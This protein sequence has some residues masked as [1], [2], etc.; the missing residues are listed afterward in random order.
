[1]D[2]N[3]DDFWVNL[4][5]KLRFLIPQNPIVDTFLLLTSATF[6]SPDPSAHGILSVLLLLLHQS[7]SELCERGRLLAKALA[8]P[9]LANLIVSL[10]LSKGLIEGSDGN[11][12]FTKLARDIGMGIGFMLPIAAHQELLRKK[13]IKNGWEA[14]TTFGLIWA[15]VWDVWPREAALGRLVSRRLTIRRPLIRLRYACT[16]S[17]RFPDTQP[18]HTIHREHRD[19]SPGR[20]LRLL[21]VSGSLHNFAGSS[22]VH[23]QNLEMAGATTHED[24]SRHSSAKRPWS[25]LSYSWQRDHYPV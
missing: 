14:A 20:N 17:G 15:T 3:D 18:N 12:F 25:N 2:S 9:A 23:P 6:A 21:G 7:H 16:P 13:L 24:L 5:Q 11:V 4:G 19:R 1:M 10:P 8:G 22:S